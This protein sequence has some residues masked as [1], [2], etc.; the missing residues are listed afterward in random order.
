M[1]EKRAAGALG[2]PAMLAG[3]FFSATLSFSATPSYFVSV[4]ATRRLRRLNA[5][6]AVYSALGA[7]VAIAFV[8]MLMMDGFGTG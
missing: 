4:P 1:L 8:V 7:A 5:R 2:P 3:L 6:R